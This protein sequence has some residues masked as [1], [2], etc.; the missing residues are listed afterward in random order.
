MTVETVYTNAR[1]ITADAVIEGSLVVRDGVIAG[2]D[3]GPSRRRRRH[4]PRR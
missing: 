3:T 1:L 2:I 4:R